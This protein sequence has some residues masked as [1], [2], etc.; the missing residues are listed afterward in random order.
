LLPLDRFKQ[1]L[2]IPFPKA[3]GGAL[4]CGGGGRLPLNELPKESGALEEGLGKG[5][6]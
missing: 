1:R 5:L 6:Q 4:T 3:V 2:K